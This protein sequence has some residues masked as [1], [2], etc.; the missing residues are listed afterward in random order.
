MPVSVT[1][2]SR[3]W[4]NEL[5][6]ITNLLQG[7]TVV[8]DAAILLSPDSRWAFRVQQ[9]TDKF[10]YNALVLDY[11]KALRQLRTNVDVVFPQQDFSRYKVIVAP[12]LLVVDR[13]L[14]T[15]LTTS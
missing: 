4:G 13:E 9:H 8:S 10:K 14:G 6:K 12:A 3:R 1:K 15:K 11:Y 2:W 7:S 5:P